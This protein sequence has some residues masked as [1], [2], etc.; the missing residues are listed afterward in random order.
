MTVPEMAAELDSKR[1][2]ISYHLRVLLR[3]RA[4]KATA[5]GPGLPAPYRWHPDADWVRKMLGQGGEFG[6]LDP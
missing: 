1:G 5:R 2:T 4:V 6:G 3:R